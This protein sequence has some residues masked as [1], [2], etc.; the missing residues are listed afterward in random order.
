MKISK[1]Q[2]LIAAG[3]LLVVLDQVIKLLV[4]DGMVPG[5][6]IDVLGEW[7]KLCYVENEGMA[8]GMKFGGV[9]GKLILSVF[10]IL[11]L[12]GLV[13]WIRS[14]YLRTPSEDGS[15]PAVPTG[16]LAG[17]TLIAAGAAGNIIDSMIYGPFL[18]G[19]VV[20]MFY[21]PLFTWPEW[22]P[23]LGGHIFFEP[24]FNF[25]DSCVTIGA[26]YLL[27]FQ[28][29]FFSSPDKKPLKEKN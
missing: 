10:R 18:F 28:Y 8:F 7:F 29:K 2:K 17:L 24:V 3:I 26:L 11:L 22:L 13:W 27:I 20:D 4:K 1:G 23:F 9:A 19:K 5:E 16:V 6:Q 25:A 12:G 14:L 21:F 15:K